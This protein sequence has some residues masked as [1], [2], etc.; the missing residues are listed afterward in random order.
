MACKTSLTNGPLSTLNVI[1]FS[2]QIPDGISQEK[3]FI[4]GTEEL[5]LL[6]SHFQV[7]YGKYS[8]FLVCCIVARCS[9]LRAET[10]V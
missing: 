3:I 10:G 6:Q 4:K 5:K 7:R 9:T 1:S 8:V 2:F